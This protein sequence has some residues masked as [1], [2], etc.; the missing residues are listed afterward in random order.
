MASPGIMID[1]SIIIDHLRKRNKQKSILFQV[2]DSHLLHAPTIV[3]FELFAGATNAA[4]RQ[5]VQRVLEPCTILPLTSE[6]AQ[7]AA[8]LYQQLKQSNQVLEIRDLFIAA[9]AIIHGY[10]LMTLNAKHFARIDALD[11]LSPPK[12]SE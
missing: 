7:H 12:L 8:H 10:P 4:K 1:T 11:L 3:E 5:D 9:T 6:I 2:V